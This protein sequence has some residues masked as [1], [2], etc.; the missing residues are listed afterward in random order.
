MYVCTYG[1]YYMSRHRYVYIH[2]YTSRG[3][4]QALSI[5]L[6]FETGSLTGLELTKLAKLALE[7]RL[8]LLPN[9]GITSTRHRT[10][11][12]FVLFCFVF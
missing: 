1:V 2:A 6:D 9:T 11:L 3:Q 10:Q 5:S 4:P 8:F 7:I 12:C